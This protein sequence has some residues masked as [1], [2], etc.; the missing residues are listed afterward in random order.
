MKKDKGSK[1]TDILSRLRVVIGTLMAVVGFFIFTFTVIVTS[2]DFS[3]ST[4]LIG[5]ILLVGGLVA[6]GSV[7]VVQFV[8]E[9][10][11]W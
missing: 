8:R 2:F 9:L 5:F 10:M 6:A 4:I 11:L 3:S 1:L 7:K